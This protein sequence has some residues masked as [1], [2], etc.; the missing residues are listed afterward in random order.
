MK[1]LGTLLDKRQGSCL[2]LYQYLCACNGSRQTQVAFPPLDSHMWWNYATYFA[3]A[4]EDL[5]LTKQLSDAETLVFVEEDA[6]TWHSGTSLALRAAFYV[7]H[8]DASNLIPQR[9]ITS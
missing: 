3:E 1:L 7:D 9:L 5:S 8:N 6:M 4:P 2:P